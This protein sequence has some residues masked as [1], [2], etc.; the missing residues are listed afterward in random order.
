M[1]TV[2]ISH[3]AIYPIW[4]FGGIRLFM[5]QSL[6][7]I[8]AVATKI[9]SASASAFRTYKASPS[10]PEFDHRI[11]RRISLLT[12]FRKNFLN[13][14]KVFPSICLVSSLA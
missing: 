9:S 7:W 5:A 6:P 1:A 10:A 8:P 11:A 12:C 14:A 4:E 3:P 2:R 13:E